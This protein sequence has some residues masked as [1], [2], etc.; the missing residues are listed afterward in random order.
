MCH[1]TSMSQITFRRKC[2]VTQLM[3]ASFDSCNRRSAMWI[4]CYTGPCYNGYRLYTLVAVHFFSLSVFME[5]YMG[6]VSRVVKL[7]TPRTMHILRCMCSKFAVKFQRAKGKNMDLI[8]FYGHFLFQHEVLISRSWYQLVNH[9]ISLNNT[10]Y[11]NCYL[12]WIAIY[13]KKKSHDK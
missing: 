12:L 5:I 6:P 8:I 1:W 13:S 3:R 9:W 10:V 2:G 7:L 4:S 11:D